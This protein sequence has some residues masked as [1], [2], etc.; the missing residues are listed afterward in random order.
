[1]AVGS[2]LCSFDCPK[3]PW[4]SFQF[5]EFF[6]PIVSA[7]V[8]VYLHSVFFSA[9]ANIYYLTFLAC[10]SIPIIFSNLNFSSNLSSLRNLTE[11][12]KKAFCYLELFWPFTIWINCSGDL[13]NFANSRPPASNFKSFSQSKEQFFLTVGQNNF[14]NRIPFLE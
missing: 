5:C 11:Q 9:W 3:Q 4:I 10:F 14:G 2:F 12:V 7:K 8:S 6:Y 13:K 1:M